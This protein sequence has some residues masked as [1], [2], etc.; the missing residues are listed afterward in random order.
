MTSGDG[1]PRPVCLALDPEPVLG[2]LHL[3]APGTQ[4][5]TAVLMCPPFGWEEMCSY[6][7]RRIWAQELAAAGYPVARIDLPGTGDSGGSSSDPEL[8]EMWTRSIS[9]TVE[10]LRDVTGA[11]RVAAIGIGVGGFIA[12]RAVA[13]G[14]AIDE[15]ALW[16][17][18]ARGRALL[19]EL[20]AHA[21]LVA[22]S[23]PEDPQR[24]PP[25][26]DGTLELIGYPLAAPAAEALAA[27]DLAT[28][29]F[30]RSPPRRVLLLGR[31]GIDT[32]ERLR[33]HFEQAGALVSIAAGTG[34]G[35]LMAHPQ[36]TQPPTQTIAATRSWLDDADGGDPASEAAWIAGPSTARPGYRRPSTE[37]ESLRLLHHGVELRETPLEFPHAGGRLFGVL[38][39]PSGTGRAGLCAVLLNGGALRHIGP[40][41]A[42]V[43]IARRWGA[44]GVTTLRVDH[45]G[46]GESDG[47]EPR[48]VGSLNGPEG[49]EQ[50][51]AVLKGLR[52]RD[53]PRRFVLGGL[54]SGAYWALHAAV[55][56]PDVVGAMMINLYAV[57][58]SEALV[59]ERERR[60]AGAALRGGIIERA[61]RGTLRREHFVRGLRSLRPSAT[62]RRG[63][64]EDAQAAELEQALDQL[65][66]RD[67]QLLFL[68]SQGEPFYDQ[69]ER[70]GYLG[71]LARW[72]NVEVE[73]IPSRDHMFRSPWLQRQVHDCL[74]AALERVL[75][76]VS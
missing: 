58:W 25:A 23:Y 24:A 57:R 37:R 31:D 22:A 53:V 54:C 10:W 63:S 3:P 4:R 65:R 16:A 45:R 29:A 64:V 21:A 27:V 55:A 5:A 34:Y 9:G 56:D 62:L 74:D 47:P 28:E 26:P 68:L 1:S 11:R 32:D 41:R 75:Q 50:A 20:R 18:P 36:E 60:A 17:V 14:A 59:L 2:F 13:A 8:V 73:R 35:Q 76:R 15:L 7:G 12:C 38:T 72:P 6:R 19:R 61:H 30:A 39:E 43:E 66:E 69:L 52:A 67:A 70:Q 71:G 44:R 33:E 49:S 40:N 42:W 48:T 51:L 46:I